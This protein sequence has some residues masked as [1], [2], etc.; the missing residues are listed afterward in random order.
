MTRASARGQAITEVALGLL[1]V[2][3]ILLGSIYL[4]E[5]AMFRLEATE[6]ATEPLWDA[7]A[8]P[9]NSYTGVFNRTPGAAATATMRAQGRQRARAILFT[10]AAAATV[11]CTAGTGM[12]ITISPTS[13]VYTDNNGISCTSSLDVAPK[14]LPRSFADQGPGAFFKEPMQ[15]FQ[16]NFRFAQNEV[17]RPFRMAIGDWG[18][19]VPNGEDEECR[20]TM[21]DCANAGFFSA[22]QTTYNSNRTG[23]G[24]QDQSF[25][26]LVEQVVISVPAD[27][28]TVTEFQMSFRGEDHG[29][30]EQ[31][32]VS[33]GDRPWRTSPSL[34]AW[35]ASHAARANGYLGLAR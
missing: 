23:G 33:E 34:D 20:L 28:P 15:S 29:F 31:V 6:A 2:V 25:L 24:T 3:P 4:A 10:T 1:L 35:A 17:N 30:I 5:V 21:S 32:P 13:G 12:G 14:W 11:G 26:H 9:H 8:Y 16:R 7:T 22:A 27:L 19:T 18:L